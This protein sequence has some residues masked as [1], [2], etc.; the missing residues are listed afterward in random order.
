MGLSSSLPFG[1]ES[2]RPGPTL[3]LS[4][5]EAHVGQGFSPAARPQGFS[6]PVVSSLEGLLHM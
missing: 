4:H 2:R 5:F 1:R 6:L 3:W